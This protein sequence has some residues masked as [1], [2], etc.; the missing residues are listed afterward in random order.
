MAAYSAKQTALNEDVEVEF[1]IA[2]SSE[3]NENQNI[4]FVEK[5][6]NDLGIPHKMTFYGGKN[7]GRRYIKGISK[8]KLQFLEESVSQFLWLDA[9]CVLRQGL[10]ML[11]NLQ[12]QSGLLHVVPRD[13]E[14]ENFN[15]GVFFSD[16]FSLDPSWKN[17]PPSSFF[18]DQHILQD[19]GK[20]HLAELPLG[21]NVLVPWGS[22]HKPA[23][24]KA[25][26]LHYVG[27]IKPWNINPSLTK[28]CIE[29][30]C[31]FSSWFE[32]EEQM[33]RVLDENLASEYSKRRIS[34]SLLVPTFTSA[35]SK[36]LMR[37]QSSNNLHPK[38]RILAVRFINA[39]LGL[40]FYSR[41]KP[42]F[43]PFH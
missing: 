28:R 38:M 35:G 15:S 29:A 14:L 24:R 23:Y 6:L 3:S 21:M 27:E 9:D 40:L 30:R 41:V 16:S 31:G 2:V 19:L 17:F 32:I 39:C 11:E 8:S 12:R 20:T 5:A 18:S 13:G 22:H 36:L 4:L 43:H 33:L 42:E 1:E 25:S 34:A 37:C 10:G 26:L 7:E